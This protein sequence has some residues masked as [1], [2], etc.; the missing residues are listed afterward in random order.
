M[1]KEPEFGVVEEV[2]KEPTLGELARAVAGGLGRKVSEKREL[3]EGE[4][5]KL[6]PELAGRIAEGTPMMESVLKPFGMGQYLGSALRTVRA[7][8]R[9]AGGRHFIPGGKEITLRRIGEIFEELIKMPQMLYRPVSK[10]EG[11]DIPKWAGLYHHKPRLIQLDIGKGGRTTPW[12]EATHAWQ[13]NWMMPER[14]KGAEIATRKLTALRDVMDKW[15][16]AQGWP[17]KE[18]YK[19]RPTETH[20]RAAADWLI[21]L[22]PKLLRKKDYVNWMLGESARFSVEDALR[23]A[24]REG[25][26]SKAEDAIRRVLAKEML[27]TGVTRWAD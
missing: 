26:G 15:L 2:P 4:A 11:T 3:W 16:G 7:V 10:I 1:V 12:H 21:R 13:Y 6:T 20:A 23:L 19:V 25:I 17:E 5:P 18:L 9:Q 22:K 14:E 8:E 24:Y 27:P